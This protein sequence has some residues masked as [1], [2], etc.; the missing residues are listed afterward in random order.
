MHSSVKETTYTF[1]SD[2]TKSKETDQDANKM[3]PVN[4]Q[5]V[6]NSGFLKIASDNTN[7]TSNPSS[8]LTSKGTMLPWGV[9]KERPN[10]PLIG[11]DTDLRPG[12]FVMRTLFIEFTVQAEKKMEI[13]MNECLVKYC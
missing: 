11:V 9:H 8:S 7:T 3:S 12:E 6:V 1:Q 4:S 2:D 5:S 13:V 10:L